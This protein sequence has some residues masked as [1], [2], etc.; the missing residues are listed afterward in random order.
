LAKTV[1]I[2][3]GR[4]AKQLEQSAVVREFTPAG[5]Q[6]AREALNALVST[7]DALQQVSED[8]SAR[9]AMSAAEHFLRRVGYDAIRAGAIHS[10]PELRD[11]LIRVLQIMHHQ[12]FLGDRDRGTELAQAFDE[13]RQLVVDI[14][15]NPES[16]PIFES[17]PLQEANGDTG[18][19][20][21][22]SAIESE[23]QRSVHNEG[24][25]Q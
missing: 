12:R 6:D 14:P 11:T 9:P 20:A 24:A 3:L 25:I 13:L 8:A 7:W 15:Q 19:P 17:V 2:E 16:L 10:F 21:F 5:Y 18:D 1:K 4:I 23:E 22:L